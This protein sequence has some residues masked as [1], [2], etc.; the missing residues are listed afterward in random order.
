MVMC[1]EI[2][3]GDTKSAVELL[4]PPEGSQP[5]DLITFEGQGRDP[6]AQLPPKDDKNPWFR[7]A[8][9]LSIDGNG[10]AK[11]KSHV[12]STPKGNITAAT[13]KNGIIN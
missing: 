13:I 6:P 11:W 4:S 5:G 9:D 8:P 3:D 2:M 12:M 10:V 7:V 1:A